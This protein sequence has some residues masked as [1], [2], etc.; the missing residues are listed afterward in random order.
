M[1]R[2]VDA[3]THKGMTV[4]EAALKLGIPKFTLGDRIS[5]RVVSGARSRQKSYLHVEEEEEFVRFIL[6]CA[7][8][9]YP[10]S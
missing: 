3:C 4:R 9:G 2:A 10:K 7:A 5:G 6:R 1:Q 8:I